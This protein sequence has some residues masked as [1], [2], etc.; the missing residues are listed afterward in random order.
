M[1]FKP[2]LHRWLSPEEARRQDSLAPQAK[3]RRGTVDLKEIVLRREAEP[4]RVKG[5]V[6]SLKGYSLPKKKG[7][8]RVVSDSRLE[9][10]KKEELSI[11][12]TSALSKLKTDDNQPSSSSE[13]ESSIQVSRS[14]DV[15]VADSFLARSSGSLSRR[16]EAILKKVKI[17]GK[18]GSDEGHE[19][20]TAMK[21]DIE[22][23][24]MDMTSQTDVEEVWFAG[25]HCG[26]FQ[27]MFSSLMMSHTPRKNTPF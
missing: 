5:G 27:I 6:G 9:A 26:E 13:N 21:E 7:H 17:G 15:A 22:A 16:T 20:P 19:S 23:Q 24:F 10:V 2:S 25:C 4:G 11:I 12:T 8:N 18:E 1:K 14:S 3:R